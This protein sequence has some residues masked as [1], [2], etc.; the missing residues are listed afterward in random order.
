[1]QSWLIAK[2]RIPERIAGL[3]G[4]RLSLGVG[5]A[6][7]MDITEWVQKELVLPVK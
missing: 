1:M 6:D 3:N 4:L 7:K 5:D 2:N